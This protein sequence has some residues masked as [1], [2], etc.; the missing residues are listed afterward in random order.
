MD[1]F[2]YDPVVQQSVVIGW[3]IYYGD[4]TTFDDRTGRWEDA[5]D[6]NVQ[7]VM[8]YEQRRDSRGR[9]YRFVMSGSDYYYKDSESFGFS[10]DD[11]AQATGSVKF[12][13]YISDEAFESIRLLAMEDFNR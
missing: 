2:R 3:R 5:P 9:C 11:R 7:V 6:H 4:G 1:Y 10:F 8:L 13:K 12:G